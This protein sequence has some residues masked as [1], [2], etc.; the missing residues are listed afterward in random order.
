MAKKL[1]Y[2][3]VAEF[4][5]TKEQRDIL[6]SLGCDIYQGYYYGKAMPPKDFVE[7]FLKNKSA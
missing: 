3:V 5:E 4:V 6:S 1:N 7:N 2:H